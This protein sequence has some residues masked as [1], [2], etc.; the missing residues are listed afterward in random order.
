[1]THLVESV[2][3]KKLDLTLSSREKVTKVSNSQLSFHFETLDAHKS[4]YHFLSYTK[5]AKNGTKK[6][7]LFLKYFEQSCKKFSLKFKFRQNKSVFLFNLDIITILSKPLILFEKEKQECFR[8]L[9]YAFKF[10]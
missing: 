6:E 4:N 5:L 10:Q 2:T 3:V 8:C 7:T 9:S 1:V